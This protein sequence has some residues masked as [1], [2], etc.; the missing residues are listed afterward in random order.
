MDVN[1]WE[2][3][4]VFLLSAVKLMLGIISALAR[5]FSYWEILLVCSSGGIAGTFFFFYL[6]REFFAL[7][8]KWFPRKNIIIKRARRIINIMQKYGK[9]GI[10]LLTPVVLSIPLGNFIAARFYKGDKSFI[11][12]MIASVV[13]WTALIA[14]FSLLQNAA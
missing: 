6:G 5:K 4:I 12:G 7:W 9:A 10:I 8:D 11:T 13:G 2:I 3:T 14:A 1:W